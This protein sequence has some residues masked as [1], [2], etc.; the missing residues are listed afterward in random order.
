MINTRPLV[1]CLKN[2]DQKSKTVP[3]YTTDCFKPS[4]LQF[5]D[6]IIPSECVW[7]CN[8]NPDLS[9]ENCHATDI[10]LTERL[11]L[12]TFISP[13][14]INLVYSY[15]GSCVFCAPLERYI[16][17]HLGQHI[18]RHLTDVSVDI[19]AECRPIWRS[20]VG[21]VSIDMSTE[22]CRSTYRP[23]YLLRYWPSDGRHID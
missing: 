5:V 2:S 19:A 16:G 15:K 9:C 1:G 13:S 6:T 23:M 12:N 3:C 8:V 22:M 4:C 14:V 17:R 10:L 20:T 7:L 11:G 21:R 18:D